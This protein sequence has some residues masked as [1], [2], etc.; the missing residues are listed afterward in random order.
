[1]LQY[2]LVM[3]GQAELTDRVH[4]SGILLMANMFKRC[5]ESSTWG[6]VVGVKGNA[7]AWSWLE[8][9]YVMT[10]LEIGCQVPTI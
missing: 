1:M 10:A 2:L 4:L 7:I 9:I 8:Y 6:P 3:A 5:D